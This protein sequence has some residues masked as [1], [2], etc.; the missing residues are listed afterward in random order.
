MTGTI[1]HWNVQKSFGYITPDEGGDDVFVSYANVRLPGFIKLYPGEKVS[2][3]KRSNEK[4]D[5]AE[6]V[7]LL[8]DT[9]ERGRVVQVNRYV[10]CN[11][12]DFL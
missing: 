8:T 4:G 2:F 6:N 12:A 5:F 7:M 9:V 3:D 11:T 10:S 1:K